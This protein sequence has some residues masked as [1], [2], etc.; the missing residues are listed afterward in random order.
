R[1]AEKFRIPVEQWICAQQI[2]GDHIRK[3]GKSDAGK[4]GTHLD[5]ALLSTDGLYTD[6]SGLLLALAYADCVPLYF[7]A[8]YDG[9]IGIAHA[10]WRGTAANIGARMVEMWSTVE[11]VAPR[12][13]FSAIGPSIGACC[14]EVDKRVIDQVDVSNPYEK[15]LTGKQVHNITTLI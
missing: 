11:G 9:L 4:G 2:H 3:V 12:D 15:C 8:P 14:Y 1:L 5:D 6:A 7:F 10:G 13:I